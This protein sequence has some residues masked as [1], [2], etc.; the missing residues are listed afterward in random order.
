M[1]L[2]RRLGLFVSGMVFRSMLLLTITAIAVVAISGNPKKIKEALVAT[3]AYERFVPSIIEA[4]STQVQSSESIPLADESIQVIINDAFPP[5]DLQKNAEHVITSLYNWL[6][7]KTPTPAFSVDLTENKAV[8]AQDLGH[9]A[10]E[11][12]AR[13]PVCTVLPAQINPF[14]SDCMPAGFDPKSQ[15]KLLV[16]QISTSPGLLPQTVFTADDLPKVRSGKVITERYDYAP[17]LYSLLIWSPWIFGFLMLTSGA[18]LVLLNKSRRLGLY[19]VGLEVLSNGILFMASPIIFGYLV[20]AVTKK[21]DLPDT[22]GAGTQIVLNDVIRY[23]TGFYDNFF[24]NAGIYMALAGLLA[25][26]TSRAIQASNGYS[27]TK[28]K[29][30]LVSSNAPR[31]HR[32]GKLITTAEHIPLQS[33]ESNVVATTEKRTTN[34]NYRTIPKKEL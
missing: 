13:Q 11:R 14:T 3:K 4:N 18:V 1:K 23:Y 6:H 30:G 24:I 20:P 28:D 21:I 17:K 26:V 29:A 22:S 16:E 8:L 5:A 33:S 7:Q 15:E 9:Y 32:Q 34:R 25:M 12:L 10:V 27:D 31:I 19:R 2:L